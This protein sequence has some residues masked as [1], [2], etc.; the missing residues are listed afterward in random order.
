M[1]AKFLPVGAALI[2]LGAPAFAAAGPTN[3]PIADIAYTAGSIDFAA[4]AH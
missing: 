2:L 3:P 4:V 1:T